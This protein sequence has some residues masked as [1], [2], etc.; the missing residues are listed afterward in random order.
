MR[1]RPASPADVTIICELLRQSGLPTQGVA[2]SI[3]DFLV[4]EMGGRIVGSIGME[5]HGSHALLRSAA[6]ASALQGRGVGRTL[7]TAL[8][9]MAAAGG[10]RSMY[11]LTTTAENY[12][13][14]FGFRP[15]DRSAVPTELMASPEFQG[16]CPASAIVMRK[17]L[18]AA[19]V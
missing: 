17:E 2:E 16:A 6:V 12:F 19:A 10:I 9:S 5:R 1:L 13:P 7:V 15:V 8:I 4:A 11:L 14:A 18:E 3:D